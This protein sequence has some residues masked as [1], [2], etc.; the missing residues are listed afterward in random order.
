MLVSGSLKHVSATPGC[1]TSRYH[2]PT[3]VS[4]IRAPPPPTRNGN[5][6]LHVKGRAPPFLL[7][8]TSHPP[9]FLINTVFVV[10]KCFPSS[11][12]RQK[13]QHVFTNYWLCGIPDVRDKVCP[14]A[15]VFSPPRGIFRMQACLLPL[16]DIDYIA[17]ATWLVGSAIQPT[18]RN[19]QRKLVNSTLAARILMCAVSTVPTSRNEK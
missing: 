10:G 4:K 8:M 12:R 14:G 17:L 16:S 19:E 11:K 18:P 15:T 7:Q 9:R 5:P 2:R 3:V 1:F 6:H 13:K